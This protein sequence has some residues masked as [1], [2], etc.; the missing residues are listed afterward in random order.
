M[1]KASKNQ[2]P[3]SQR[4]AITT[5]DLRQ[6]RLD[7]LKRLFPDLFDG[8]GHLD[9]KALRSLVSTDDGGA[10]ERFRFEWAGKLQS[11][12]I[13][14]TPSRATLVA[15]PARSVDFDK[16]Q[17][18]I[19][20]GDNLE[21]LKLLQT[22]YFERVKC[23]YIDPPYNTGNDF[24]YRDDFS[25][26]KKPYWKKNGTV[27]DGVKLISVTESNGRKHSIWLNMMQS[28]LLLAR[29]LLREDGVVFISVDEGE[30]SNL[31]KLG[32]DIFGEENYVGEIVWRN[33]SKNDQAY[34]SMQHEYILC[35]VKNRSVNDGVWEERKEGLE[36]IYRQ[37]EKLKKEFRDNWAA[38]H[39]AALAWYKQFPPSHPI[40]NS[41]HYNWMDKNGVYFPDNISGPNYGQYRYDVIHPATGKVCKE[42][43]SGWRYPP[44]TMLQ[45][46]KDGLVHF[47]E[48]ET[49]V[50]NNKTYLKNTEN[51][52]LSSVRY[53]DGR[54]ASK[55]LIKL[56]DG[57]YFTNPKDCEL[58]ASIMRAIKVGGNDIVLDFFAGSGTTAET[59]M[60]LNAQDGGKRRHILVQ[61]PEYTDEKSEAYKVGYKTISS[62]CIERAKRAGAKIRAENPNAKIDTGFRVYRLTD[63]HFS[64]NFFVHDATK[65]EAENMAALDAYLKTHSQKELFS[66]TAFNDIVTE[67]ALK[68]GYGLFYTLEKQTT[69]SR[70]KVY[71][72]SG[73]DKAAL[74]CLDDTLHEATVE[75]LLEHSDEQLILPSH[76]LD[77]TKKWTLQNS[78]K[79]N[80]YTV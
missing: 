38:I 12:R 5:P 29:Q 74:L 52:S 50:P 73:N 69:F 51:Q 77:T 71:R 22:T 42:P 66:A 14:F 10:P 34:I 31:R 13:A 2:K 39:V 60:Q 49:T 62:F 45:R 79:A 23:I 9:E 43:S 30:F 72:L 63:S 46:I 54:V 61:I 47:G 1:T 20:E 8:E 41:K 26:G 44:E 17:N 53:K 78:F 19:L 6:D 21:V 75:A 64:Q 11:K 57:N 37:F 28:R 18:L 32:E 35:F 27:K 15:A 48:D 3:E 76:A 56:M 40:S 58:L 65:S 36:E 67:I 68:N 59:V 70:N 80:L 4:A 55:N 25:E 16:T 33:S 24:I 7:M